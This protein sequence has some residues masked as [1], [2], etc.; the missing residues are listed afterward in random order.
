MLASRLA[1]L[2][3]SVQVQVQRNFGVSAVVWQKTDP[4]QQLFLD[5]LKEYKQKNIAK[6]AATDADLLGEL[7][8]LKG[9]YK[10]QP[11]EDM[12]TLSVPKYQDIS[13][14]NYELGLTTTADGVEVVEAQ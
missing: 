8:R 6:E 3:R 7:D 13:V 1:A 10:V 4:I 9:M 5:K 12:T 14:E 2:G 11:G